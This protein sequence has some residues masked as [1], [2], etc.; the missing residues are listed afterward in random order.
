[1]DLDDTATRTILGIQ[2]AATCVGCDG[3]LTAGAA[4]RGA[5][6][7]CGLDGA[8]VRPVA[9]GPVAA[10]TANDAA[11]DDPVS[12]CL[13]HPDLVHRFEIL[14]KLGQGGMGA[15]FVARDRELDREV[16]LKLVLGCGAGE[17]DRLRREG[18]N[19]AQLD[20]PRILRVYSTMICGEAAVLVLELLSG[21]PLSLDLRHAGRYAPSRAVAVMRLVLEGLE[22]AHGAGIVHRDLKPANILLIGR[23]DLKILDFGLARHAE[24]EECGAGEGTS[25]AASEHITRTGMIVGTPAYMSP[26][27]CRAGRP[28]PH[29]DIYACGVILH[30][31]VSG[32]LPFTGA[33]P[34]EI[35]RKQVE[36]APPSLEAIA[37]DVPPRLAEVARRALAK[38]PEDRFQSASAMMDA[39]RTAARTPEARSRPA[40]STGAGR[41]IPVATAPAAGHRRSAAGLALIAATIL[42]LIAARSY[43]SVSPPGGEPVRASKAPARA[44]D[45]PVARRSPVPRPVPDSSMLE[46]VRRTILRLSR[47]DPANQ[48]RKMESELPDQP[49]V[50]RSPTARDQR[51]PPPWLGEL[52]ARWTARLTRDRSDLELESVCDS[53][54]SVKDRAFASS[55]VSVSEKRT[56]YDLTRSILGLEDFAGH[57]GVRLPRLYPRL[58]ST[59]YGPCGAV[60][61]PPAGGVALVFQRGADRA[62]PSPPV[63]AR[64]IQIG[65]PSV[66]AQLVAFAD[67]DEP[68]AAGSIISSMEHAQ[69]S[70]PDPIELP[71]RRELSRLV[72]SAAIDHTRLETGLRVLAAGARPGD[73]RGDH[74]LLAVLR[75]YALSGPQLVH[76]ALPPD[77]VPAGKVFLRMRIDYSRRLAAL[78]DSAKQDMTVSWLA[79]SW[80]KRR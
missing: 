6:P 38:R 37:P 68:V 72:L 51:S 9:G 56:L 41:S 29:T 21:V 23:D 1:M 50:S 10:T 43:R 22:A 44:P 35:M 32:C 12:A 61:D 77:V 71:D 18:R 39:L 42:L 27:Q 74:T 16:A 66:N 34:F 8:T 73:P 20:H 2:E 3:P 26:E 5:C 70:I 62:S 31:M 45:A 64:Q 54:A 19:L 40:R 13:T 11:Q 28:D 52:A 4:T 36:E 75:P 24:H 17:R 47:F 65:V 60:A 46:V 67:P 79:L 33:D 76:H 57:A 80:W 30:E 78:S 69:V 63:P 59:R 14:R 55:D 48:L 25:G 53:F 15:V 7:T 49:P 58:L